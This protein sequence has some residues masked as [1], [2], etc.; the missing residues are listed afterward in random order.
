MLDG[1]STATSVSSVKVALGNLHALAFSLVFWPPIP[2]Y[3]KHDMFS[4]FPIS[5]FSPTNNTLNY[6]TTAQDYTCY[7]DATDLT[8]KML[9]VSWT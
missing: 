9:M 6:L 2:Q 5:L 8:F 7:F 3:E 1:S 4:F